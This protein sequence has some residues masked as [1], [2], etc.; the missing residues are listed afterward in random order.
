MAKAAAASNRAAGPIHEQNRDHRRAANMGRGSHPRA[1]EARQARVPQE[2]RSLNRGGFVSSALTAGRG[3]HAARIESEIV[4]RTP[5]PD[6]AS[7]PRRDGGRPG[8][9][10]HGPARR[11]PRPTNR[12]CVVLPCADQQANQSEKRRGTPRAARE[13]RAPG[14]ARQPGPATP[15]RPQHQERTRDSVDGGRQAPPRLGGSAARPGRWRERSGPEL[16]ARE[17][18]TRPQ[19][20]VTAGPARRSAA[21]RARA[22]RPAIM[23]RREAHDRK[24]VATPE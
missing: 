1:E 9:N 19:R 2:T 15:T 18:L 16:L 8:L 7:A 17:S 21:R 23:R 22:T 11:C 12:E 14:P 13:A 4:R 3:T 5:R 6:C 24:E 20:T 10:Q